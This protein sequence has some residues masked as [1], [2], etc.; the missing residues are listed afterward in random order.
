LICQ[1]TYLE[2]LPTPVHNF[3]ATTE[4]LNEEIFH[5]HLSGDTGKTVV[6]AMELVGGTVVGVLVARKLFQMLGDE[7]KNHPS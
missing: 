3:K 2:L 7:D 4:W 6:R 1:G 5:H